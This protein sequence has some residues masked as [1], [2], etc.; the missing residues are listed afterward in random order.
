MQTI[1]AII[2]VWA[3]LSIVA[4]LVYAIGLFRMPTGKRP[5]TPT[6]NRFGDPLPAQQNPDFTETENESEPP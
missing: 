4:F 6:Y 1:E 5:K 2:A 3:I